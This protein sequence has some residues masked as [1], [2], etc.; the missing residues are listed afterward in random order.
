MKN[1][2]M[3]FTTVFIF[4]IPI[5]IFSQE[6]IF[7]MSYN[8]RLGSVDDK[9]NHWNIRKEKLTNLIDYY[10]ADFIGLQEAQAP[11][12]S[13]ILN[14]I[15]DYEMIGKGRDVSET[16]EFSCILYNKNYFRLIKEDTFWLSETPQKISKSWDA[17]LPRICT[18]G[19]FQNIKSKKMIWVLNTHFDHIGVNAR[20][21]AAK[22]ILEKIK[23][24]GKEKN[25]PLIF[26]GDLNSLPEDE[27]YSILTNI[28]QDTRSICQTK[29]YGE[30]DTWENF[31]FNKKPS[32]QIDYIF[33]TNSQKY[34]VKKY[35]TI[36]DFYDFKYPSDHLP[37]FVH[38]K[39][40]KK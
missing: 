35:R 34:S 14:Q 2:K 3:R 13:Y 28:L 4:L 32:G 11:Q 17:A 7:V 6:S 22:M 37:I 36:A 39:W 10:D 38:L 23:I 29:P 19:L 25:I 26:M 12:L 20:R 9:E 5:V 16:T 1:M 15:N 21:N 18:Y 8:I 30:K 24:L 31:E 40:D 33:I 27:P